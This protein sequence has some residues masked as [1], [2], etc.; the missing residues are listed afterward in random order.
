MLPWEV[1][2]VTWKYKKHNSVSLGQVVLACAYHNL[3]YVTR[4]FFSGPADISYWLVQVW[5]QA[6]FL[7]SDDII[8][9][10]KKHDPL[11][12]VLINEYIEYF[13]NKRN[14][15]Q[16]AS[17]REW[18]PFL[19]KRKNEYHREFYI[20]LANHELM[21]QAF[22]HNIFQISNL[23][24]VVTTTSNKLAFTALVKQYCLNLCSQ[25]FDL[26]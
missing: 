24:L 9:A 20:F 2:L 1:V 7:N 3:S 17:T 18:M 26:V 22:W 23:P 12:P 8:N 13:A 6:Y 11:G 5:G 14:F 4:E 15:R 25:Q 21:E 19:N 10:S 16:R